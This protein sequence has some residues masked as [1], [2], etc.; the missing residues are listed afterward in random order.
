MPAGHQYEVGYRS[1]L[2]TEVAVANVIVIP[3]SASVLV[4]YIYT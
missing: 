2:L 4:L 3:L 1:R